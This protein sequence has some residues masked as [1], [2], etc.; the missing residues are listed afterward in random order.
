M[1]AA[2]KGFLSNRWVAALNRRMTITVVGRTLRMCYLAPRFHERSDQLTSGASVTS[3]FTWQPD[4][5]AL[6]RR[7]EPVIAAA[8][9]QLLPPGPSAL[10]LL[11]LGVVIVQLK[12]ASGLSTGSHAATSSLNR[13]SSDQATSRAVVAT[14]SGFHGLA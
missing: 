10:A 9:A 12:S 4:P 3:A 2:G 5:A 7:V 11:R 8:S 13:C 6:V 14:G 1:L